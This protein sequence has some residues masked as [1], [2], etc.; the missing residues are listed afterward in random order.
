[1]ETYKC[2][3]CEKVF[4]DVPPIT[5]CVDCGSENIV[6]YEEYGDFPQIKSGAKNS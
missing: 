5:Y 1:M 2:L 6:E 4:T 3:D